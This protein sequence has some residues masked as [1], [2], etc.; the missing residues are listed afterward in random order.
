MDLIRGQHQCLVAEVWFD[1][2]LITQGENPA[3]CEG[4]AQR[5]LVITESDNPGVP[6]T[7]TVQHTFELKATEPQPTALRCWRTECGRPRK[8]RGRALQRLVRARPR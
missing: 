5:N 6:A 1:K 4:L 7:H 2:H 8:Y 3:S